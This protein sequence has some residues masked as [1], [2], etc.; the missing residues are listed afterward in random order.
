MLGAALIIVG[1]VLVGAALYAIRAPLARHRALE[2]TE[3]NLRRYDDWRGSRL[4]DDS[5]RTGAD[6][7]KDYLWG[8]VRLWAAVALAGVALI[9]AGLVIR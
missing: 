2:A 4:V 3:A 8:R 1:A 6:E 5:E 7:M 9:V